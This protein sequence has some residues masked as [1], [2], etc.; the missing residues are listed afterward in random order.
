MCLLQSTRRG[1]PF[2]EVGETGIL[3]LLSPRKRAFPPHAPLRHALDRHFTRVSHPS[4]HRPKRPFPK[5]L[6]DS[7]PTAAHSECLQIGGKGVRYDTLNT[8]LARAGPYLSSMRCTHTHTHT[9]ASDLPFQN[10]ELQRSQAHHAITAHLRAHAHTRTRED[11]SPSEAHTHTHTHT[12]RPSHGTTVR[13]KADADPRKR[14]QH[15]HTQK[16]ES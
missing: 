10:L 7:I 6:L 2:P 5:L 8:V 16:N 14:W 1:T 11:R 4:P 3:L 13:D 12:H 9:R 15:K